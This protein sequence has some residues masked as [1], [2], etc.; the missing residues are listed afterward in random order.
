M[1]PRLLAAYRATNY[2]VDAVMIRIGRRS[3]PMDA[4]LARLEAR[5]A[6]FITAWNPRP[7]RM[8]QGWN[9]RMQRRLV[10]H[11]RRYVTRPASGSLG[12]WHEAHL[13]VAADP[14]PIVRLA[15]LFRQRGVVVISR[16]QAAK[17]LLLEPF[18]L[19]LAGLAA[20]RT[21]AGEGNANRTHRPPPSDRR[22]D[23]TD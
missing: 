9:H 13:L 10:G 5:T 7:R 16:H 11:L 12:R 21:K 6:V 23:P 1:N 14:R 15:R 22:V 2:A 20:T 17:L 8:P 18:P 3:A 19:P 4:L